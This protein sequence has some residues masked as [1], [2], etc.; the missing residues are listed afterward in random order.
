MDP[1]AN[2]KEM[3]ELADQTLMAERADR[4]AMR[5]AELVE[6]MDDWLRG[7]GCLPEHWRR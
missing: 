7:G 1:D 6:A 3:L 2:L 5:L 4:S